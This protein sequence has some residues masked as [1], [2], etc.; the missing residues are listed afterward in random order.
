MQRQPSPEKKMKTPS[1]T[2]MNEFNDWENAPDPPIIGKVTYC[3][4]ELVWNKDLIDGI[5]GAP[6]TKSNTSV[7][8][9]HSTAS[10]R[11]NDGCRMK[12]IVQ[13]EEIGGLVT[14][15]FGTIYSGFAQ[16]NTFNGLDARTMY[17]YRIKYKGNGKET[18]WSRP[19]EVMT[20]KKPPSAE[21]LHKAVLKN[22]LEAVQSLLEELDKGVIDACDKFGYTSLMSAVSKGHKDIARLLIKNH[23]DVDCQTSSNK[24]AL[25]VASFTGNFEMVRL[26]H[27]HGCRNTMTDNSGSTALHYAVDSGNIDVIRYLIGKGLH[28]DQKDFTSG[29][30]PLMRLASTSGDLTVAR[31]LL[32]NRADANAFDTTHKS[33]LMMAALNGHTSLVKL[34]VEKGAKV[35]LTSAH[36]KTALDFARSFDHR[37]IIIFLESKTKELRKGNNQIP[38]IGTKKRMTTV[39]G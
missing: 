25:M 35:D 6:K 3:S 4:L 28:V 19:V 30:T 2:L 38:P 18:P 12:Y 14:K 23:A 24:N 13:E 20:T 37:Q 31:V 10:T 1:T 22:D 32:Q 7:Y 8:S 15:G 5:T 34:L 39:L 36:N 16:R 9:L 11:S 26:L 17:R 27:D 21:D 33:V 29:W